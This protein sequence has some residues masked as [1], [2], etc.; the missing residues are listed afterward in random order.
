MPIETLARPGSDAPPLALRDEYLSPLRL[1]HLD[2]M[3]T[4]IGIWQHSA[5]ENPDPR[6]GYSIDDEARGLIVALGYWQQGRDAGFMQRLGGTCFRFI[7][8][9]AVTEGP[10]AGRYHNF[11]DTEGQWLDSIGSDDSFG[12]TLWGLGAAHATDAPFAPRRTAQRLLHGSLAQIDTLQADWL[13][14]KAFVVLGLRLSRLDDARFKTLADALADAFEATAG[15][16]WQWYENHMTYCNARLPMA[17]FAA[18]QVFPEEA[19]YRQIA[20]QSL[21]FLLR[22]TRDTRG[23]YSPIG[24]AR[25]ANAGWFQRGEAK[26]YQWDQQPVDAGA[27]VECCALAANV[28]GEAHYAEAARA[29]FGWYLGENWHGLP[30]YDPKTGAVADALHEHGIS[31]NLGAESVVSVHLAWQALQTLPQ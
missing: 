14:A 28:T 2:T 4:E 5:G 24:N 3:L 21:D 25:M 8:D 16:N 13:R 17:L 19:R 27:L 22:V 7:R 18:S 29:A 6:H 23:N 12:R 30:I 1:D 11:C 26:P 9:A 20:M 10:Q 15:S 31:R